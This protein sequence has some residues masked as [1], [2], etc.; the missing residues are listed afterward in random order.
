MKVLVTGATGFVGRRFYQLATELGFQLLGQSRVRPSR[1]AERWVETCIDSNTKWSK[2][3]NKVDC[4]VHCAARVHQMNESADDANALYQEVNVLG[5]L[6]LASQAAHAGVKRFVFLSSIKVNGESTSPNNSFK[7]EVGARPSDP[8]GA[9]KW[10]AEQG[11]LEI[12]KETGL[13]VVI[14]R[15]PLVYGPGVKANFHSLLKWVDRAAPLPLGAINNQRSMVFLD[16]LVSLMLECCENPNA[17]GQTFL[18]SDE[19]DISTSGLLKEVATA[20]KRP[21]RMLPIPE[22]WLKLAASLLGKKHVGERLC[23]SLQ[24][25][26]SHTKQQLGWVP[27]VSFSEGIK[28]TVDDYLKQKGKE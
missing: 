12:A 14:I 8:Y 18:V 17:A 6:N 23:S 21:Y 26:I 2:T 9:S 16:N 7:P 1:D 3:L 27:P 20:M 25:D 10:D 11:L 22:S 28:E 19:H 13:E 5:T 15:P 24:L 4:V